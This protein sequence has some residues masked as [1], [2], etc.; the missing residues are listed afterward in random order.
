MFVFEYSLLKLTP[1]CRVF[2][3][4]SLSP[5]Q[6]FS[7]SEKPVSPV[8]VGQTDVEDWTKHRELSGTWDMRLMNYKIFNAC[9]WSDFTFLPQC[10]KA[11]VSTCS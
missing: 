8:P 6:L 1:V 4:L 2:L 3:Q 11:A 7:A 9:A 5:L 10:P